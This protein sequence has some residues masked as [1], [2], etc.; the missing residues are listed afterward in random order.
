MFL[1]WY[2]PDKKK[3]V[4]MKFVEACERYTERFGGPAEM[5]LTSV[6][7]ADELN[8]DSLVATTLT[9]KGIHYIPRYTFYLGVEEPT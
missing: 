5:C 9:I 6:V 7:D 3:P 8:A 2:D 1:G 4:R